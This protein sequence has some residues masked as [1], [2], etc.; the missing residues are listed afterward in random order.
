[1]V[2]DTGVLLDLSL[3]ALPSV[4]RSVQASE[5]ESGVTYLLPWGFGA[6]LTGTNPKE[7]ARLFRTYGVPPSDSAVSLFRESLIGR[8]APQPLVLPYEIPA[9]DK[10]SALSSPVHD[11]LTSVVTEEF[12]EAELSRGTVRY[13]VQAYLEMIHALEVR[14]HA[15][16]RRPFGL[17]FATSPK[18]LVGKS[19]S[20][21]RRLG[22]PVTTR[23]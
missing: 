14:S 17:L 20:I 6:V 3:F 21:I 15:S 11:L 5:G 12:R 8:D 22:R 13:M 10:E 19:L 7:L 1:M 18:D 16:P 23:V 2:E 9:S 4:L